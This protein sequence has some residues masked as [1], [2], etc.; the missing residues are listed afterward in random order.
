M[1]LGLTH[2]TQNTALL[3]RGTSSLTALAAKSIATL[4]TLAITTT[5]GTG[6]DKLPM[7]RHGPLTTRQDHSHDIPMTILPRPRPTQIMVQ[8]HIRNPL[9]I[10]TRRILMRNTR[11]RHRRPPVALTRPAYDTIRLL[12]DN[13]LA[14]FIHNSRGLHLTTNLR[15]TC[16][17]NCPHTA[18]DPMRK[19]TMALR[20]GHLI[21]MLLSNPHGAGPTKTR[22]RTTCRIGVI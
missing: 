5:L 21:P 15:I 3:D 1:G 19:N 22:Q 7:I 10:D 11:V 4:A 6:S 9:L 13:D 8:R 14:R 17:S 16:T 2:H 12:S 20:T 18:L